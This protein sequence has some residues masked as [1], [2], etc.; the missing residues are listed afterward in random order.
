MIGIYKISN[1]IN[2]KAYIGYS[3]NIEQRWEYHLTHF[4]CTKEYNKTLY[5]AF[6]KYGINSFSF[7]IIEECFSREELLE[8][9]KYWIK[10]YNTFL[11][12]YN[13]TEGGD[14]RYLLGEANNWAILSEKEVIE[15]RLAYSR[16]Q[17]KVELYNKE[18]KDKI[19]WGGFCQVWQGITW[20]HIM[21][22][23]YTNENKEKIIHHHRKVNIG[24]QNGRSKLTEEQ[25]LEIIYKLIN[26]DI[27]QTQLGKDYGVSYN[28]INGINR[29]KNW[30]HLHSYI[31]N[32]RLEGGDVRL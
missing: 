25:V 20:K 23:V 11:N 6:R 28:T 4:N 9:E 17:S 30:T 15:I 22:E 31:N 27:S 2:K 29:C 26:T 12:G 19:S 24:S 16:Q 5:K 8:R 10:F 14:G 1:K 13:E 7:E 18:Y 32:I 3:N 21:P